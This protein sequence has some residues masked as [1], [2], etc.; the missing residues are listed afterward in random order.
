MSRESDSAKRMLAKYGET[1]VITFAGLPSYNPITGA[2][3]VGTV[4]ASYTAKG[5]PSRYGKDEIDGAT[6]MTNDVRLILELI[7]QRPEV[8]CTALVDGVTYRVMNVK[9]IRKSGAD[10]IYICGIRR[11]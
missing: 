6:I 9:P 3:E 2:V 1:V 5:Y 8:G 10:V 11:N 7:D 4:G